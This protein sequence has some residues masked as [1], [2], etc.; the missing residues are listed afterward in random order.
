MC[1]Y[2]CMYVCVCVCECLGVSVSLLLE[3]ERVSFNV[4]EMFVKHSQVHQL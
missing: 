3:Y 2:V 1:V 4:W